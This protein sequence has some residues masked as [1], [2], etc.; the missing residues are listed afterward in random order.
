MI[1]PSRSNEP[2]ALRRMPNIDQS[3][4]MQLSYLNANTTTEATFPSRAEFLFVFAHHH[5]IF[6]LQQAKISW[7]SAAPL[8]RK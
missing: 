6:L 8:E 5:G 1:G 3:H 2:N 7:Y 4:H